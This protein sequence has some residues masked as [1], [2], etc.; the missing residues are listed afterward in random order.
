MTSPARAHLGKTQ[1]V[2]VPTATR[3]SIVWLAVGIAPAVPVSLIA[4]GDAAVD[5]VTVYLVLK[6]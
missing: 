3:W 5:Y 1:D 4:G 6:A 2:S